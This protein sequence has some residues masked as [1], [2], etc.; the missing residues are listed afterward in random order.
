ME[1]PV[2]KAPSETKP[3]RAPTKAQRD[4]YKIYNAV[5]KTAFANFFVKPQAKKKPGRPPKNRGVGRPPKRREPTPEEQAQGAAAAAA[6]ATAEAAATEALGRQV[7]QT[8][9]PA[10]QRRANRA[11]PERAALLCRAKA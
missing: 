5:E 1:K 7:A 4:N 10:P 3:A 2:Q 11:T 6:A 9:A 8:V